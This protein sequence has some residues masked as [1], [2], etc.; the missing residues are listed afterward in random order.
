MLISASGRGLEWQKSLRLQKI[1]L[2]DRVQPNEITQA[3]A[4]RDLHWFMLDFDLPKLDAGY[5]QNSHRIN[6][7]AACVLF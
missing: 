4:I 3:A 6:H 1:L 7:S 5:P 2:L